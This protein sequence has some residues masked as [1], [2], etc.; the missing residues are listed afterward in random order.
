MPPGGI[1]IK[2]G[3]GNG[4]HNGLK[5]IQSHLGTP[6]FWRL[7]LGIGHPGDRNE[8]IGYVLKP[9]RREER[10]LIDEAL[11]RSLASWPKLGA[12]DYAAAQQNL[13]GKAA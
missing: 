6:D 12:G 1:R 7:R 5:D 9:P 2:Q 3:G 4:G 11:D 8:V 13:H 10:E